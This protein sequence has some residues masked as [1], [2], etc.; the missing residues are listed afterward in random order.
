MLRALFLFLLLTPC[1]FAQGFEQVRDLIRRGDFAAAVQSCDAAL[2]K[3]PRDHQLWT[4]KGIALQGVGQP[5]ESLAAFRRALALNPKFLPALQGAA[6]LE[7]QLHDPNCRKTL[8]ALLQLRPEPT[9]HAMLGALAFES[10][11]CAATLQH[12]AAAGEAAQQPVI[13]WQRAT[14]SFQLE[15][16]DAAATQFRELLALKE[17]ARIRYNLGLAESRAN[18]HREA[19]AVLQPLRA[20][21]DADALSLLASV[22]EANKQTPEALEVLREAITRFPLEERLYA[23]LATICLDHNALALGVEVLA[24]GT[25][26]LPQSAR[27]Q[28]LLG[29]LHARA[30]QREQAE[31]AFKRAEHLAPEAAFGRVGLAVAMMESGAVN[32]AITQLRE[33]LKRTPTDARVRLTLAQALL[34]K[35]TSPAELKEAHTILRSLITQQPNQARAHS[36]LGKLYLRQ[37]NVAQAARALETAIRLDPADRNSTYQLMTVYRKQGRLKEAAALQEKVQKLLDEERAADVEAARYRLVRAP[38]GRPGQ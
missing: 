16:W 30:E 9:V 18:K 21:A 24:A 25:K 14:C 3:Q 37:D 10:K 20:Q 27:L 23:D 36:L 17:D 15:D 7:Y 8:A 34:Q 11:D 22:Y 38:E 35:D 29:V 31:A 19:I 28:T 32:E 2:Q 1:A 13:K 4:L 5:K 12:Y 26:N 33:Q 6:Q